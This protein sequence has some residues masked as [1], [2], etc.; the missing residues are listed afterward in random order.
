MGR[1]LR[2]DSSETDGEAAA[3]EAIKC[4]LI[5]IETISAEGVVPVGLLDELRALKITYLED[6]AN[7]G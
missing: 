7:D 6:W 3:R 4:V 5:H 1:Y 2:V